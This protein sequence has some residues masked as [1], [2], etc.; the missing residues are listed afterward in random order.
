MTTDTP[1]GAAPLRERAGEPTSIDLERAHRCV[2]TLLVAL[3]QAQRVGGKHAKMHIGDAIGII[4]MFQRGD[5]D[6]GA[7][8]TGPFY[9]GDVV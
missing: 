4:E 5:M 3:R 6:N 8:I 7:P 1:A 9:P 2:Q